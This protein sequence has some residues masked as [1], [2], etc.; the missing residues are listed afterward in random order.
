MTYV[1]IALSAFF[2]SGLTLF[3][4]F[5]LGTVLTPI[6]ILFFPTPIAISLTA[7]VHFLNNIFKL[8]LLGK[9]GDR[10]VLIKFGIPAILGAIVGS[11]T[12]SFIAQKSFI[13][14]YHLFKNVFSVELINLTIGILIMFFVLLEILP[15]LNKISFDKNLLPLGGILSGFFGGLSGNQGA[16]RS[17][18]LLK[19]NLS[20]EKF[21]ATSAILS[22]LVDT[23][24]ISIYGM[25]FLNKEITNNFPL[26]IIAVLSA[27]LGSYLSK[28]LMH[29]ITI[30]TV[31]ILVLLMLLTISMGLITGFI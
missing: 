9:E 12:L 5:G 24:R 26:L 23:A 7:I 4:G 31:R 18:F 2:I 8:F 28:K 6:F 30:K 15:L 10:E 29:K 21:I 1:I 11:L 17:V 27:F 19:C 20:K 25:N 14:N 16:F 22:C 13:I 3:S